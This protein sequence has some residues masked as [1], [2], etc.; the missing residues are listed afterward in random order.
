[1]LARTGRGEY[2][3]IHLL[4]RDHLAECAPN[5]L[6][7]KVDRRITERTRSRVHS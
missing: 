4:V 5:H 6:A 2:S 3:F 1:V 7:T